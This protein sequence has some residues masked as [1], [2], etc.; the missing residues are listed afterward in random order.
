[1]KDN[2]LLEN[3]RESAYEISQSATNAIKYGINDSYL[4]RPSNKESIEDELTNLMAIYF[5]L[6]DNK[7][8]NK[9]NKTD[10]SKRITKIKSLL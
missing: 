3:L 10:I 7:I 6:S 9:I 5:I 4:G 1:M 2:E 8:I